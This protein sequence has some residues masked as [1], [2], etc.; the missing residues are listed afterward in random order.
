MKKVL[1]IE[2]DKILSEMYALKLRKEG[3]EVKESIN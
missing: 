3:F 2:D 1:I